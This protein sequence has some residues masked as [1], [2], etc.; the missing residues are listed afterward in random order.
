MITFYVHPVGEGGDQFVWS[1]IAG[2]NRTL[3]LRGERGTAKLRNTVNHIMTWAHH[4]RDGHCQI[5]LTL[6]AERRRKS[7]G[8]PT[9]VKPD[10]RGG[11]T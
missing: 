7:L 10:Y 2:N 9:Y 11:P 3:I 5:V 4:M 1:A 8:L 6:G